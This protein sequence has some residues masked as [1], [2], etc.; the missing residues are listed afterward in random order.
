MGG[1]DAAV[2]HDADADALI[3][4]VT[5]PTK[6]RLENVEVMAG[7]GDLEM[8]TET[9]GNQPSTN[10]T[11]QIDDN[12]QHLSTS[13][14]EELHVDATIWSPINQSVEE[15]DA[16]RI[17]LSLAQGA[18]PGASVP[19]LENTVD[20]PASPPQQHIEVDDTRAAS[21]ANLGMRKKKHIN[22]LSKI[23][24][25]PSPPA[26]VEL[27]DLW[28]VGLPDFCGRPRHLGPRVKGL[29]AMELEISYGGPLPKTEDEEWML[30]M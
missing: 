29:K 8:E 26:E 12:L 2:A 16:P 10:P 5:D 13:I 9:S 21:P 3:E 28:D 22:A 17:L 1:E 20:T 23:K 24:P 27:D 11:L 18:T 14:E 25:V 4:D 7:R 6:S 19:H 30:G 15:D